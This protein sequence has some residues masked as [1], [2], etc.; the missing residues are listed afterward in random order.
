MNTTLRISLA[1]AAL[2][3]ASFSSQAAD[4]TVRLTGSTAFR[5]AV[6][7]TLTTNFFDVAPVLV[8]S[9]ATD[10]TGVVTFVGTNTALFGASTRVIIETAYSG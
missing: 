1:A 6:Y 5:A 10:D 8:P 7:R 4:V 9:S 2:G 3:A